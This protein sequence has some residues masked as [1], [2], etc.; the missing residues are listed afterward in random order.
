MHTARERSNDGGS[1]R[2][3][4]IER[5][6]AMLGTLFVAANVAVACSSEVT[7][8]S[9]GTGGAGGHAA[10]GGMTTSPGGAGAGGSSPTGGASTGGVAVGGASTGGG[11][12][13]SVGG[14][15]SCPGYG[16]VCT[17]CISDSC[18][19]VWCAC[20]SEPHCLGYLQCL[21]T[22]MPGDA[23]CAQ[24]CANVHEPGISAAILTA[25]CAGTTCDASC[26]FGKALPDCQKCLYTSCP[27][28]MNACIA[29]AECIALIQCL[30]ACAP[31]DMACSQGCVSDHQDGLADVQAIVPCRNDL[32][33]DVCP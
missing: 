19:D 22:C 29:N 13:T 9:S 11:G 7:V 24:S 12:S 33:G 28:E 26:D 2:L 6:A 32:C 17:T 18:A 8:E 3:T 4:S 16:D 30:Q 5:A 25:D 20:T 15:A 1:R 31:G 21:G 14:S 27:A 23:T 10:T